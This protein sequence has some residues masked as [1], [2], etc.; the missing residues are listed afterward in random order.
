MKVLFSKYG[1]IMKR[2]AVCVRRLSLLMSFAALLCLCE[3]YGFNSTFQTTSQKIQLQEIAS[4]LQNPVFVTHAYDARL[5]IVEQN[6]RIRMYNR[7]GGVA[8]TP[9]LDLASIVTCCGEQGLLG[10]AFHPNYPTT[11]YFYVYFSS[12]GNVLPDG[13]DPEPSETILMR[14]RKSDADSNLADFASGKTLLKMPQPHQNHNGGMIGFGWGG[15]LY[16]GKGDGGSQN[17]PNNLAQNKNVL[18]GKILRLDVNQNFE[19]PPYYGI[20]N[21]NPFAGAM[22]GADE[23]F[24]FGLRNPWRFSF[25]RELGD[26]WIGDVGQGAREEINRFVFRTGAPGGAN[27]GWR[28]YEGTLCTNLDS[29]VVPADY[30]APV[31]EYAHTDG[32]CSIT[33]G[34]VYRG[35]N[36]GALRGTYVYA[37][38]CTGEIFALN[39]ATQMLLLDTSVFVSSFGED[40]N[41]EL[42]ITASNGSIYKIQ[43]FSPTP[44]NISGRV[45]S[46]AGR[47]LANVRLILS[48][49]NLSEPRYAQTNAFGYYRFAGVPV[50]LDYV[51]TVASK[52]H[53]FAVANQTFTLNGERTGTNFIAARGN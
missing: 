51:I 53:N 29:C 42:Y 11:P 6:G 31:A 15:Y 45:F 5:F 41:G 36:I 9:F 16:V 2:L 24:L 28:I 4:G 27:F 49:G 7:S 32:R 35:A 52:R 34:Y 14:F 33:G 3:I 46:S 40:L 44:A 1:F 21:D 20:P 48:G 13:V 38:Y 25:D 50:G 30:L 17:D 39:D 23:V 10:L 22:P 8:P 47:G 12:N 19:R 43:F 18:L 26:L 37:D